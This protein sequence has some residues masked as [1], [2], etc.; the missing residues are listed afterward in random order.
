M[1]LLRYDVSYVSINK[2]TRTNVIYFVFENFAKLS[3]VV[4][5]I[6]YTFILYIAPNYYHIHDPH[7][8]K[9]TIGCWEL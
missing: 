4:R 1:L 7:E 5:Q 2:Q 9:N 6:F 8:T 3:S